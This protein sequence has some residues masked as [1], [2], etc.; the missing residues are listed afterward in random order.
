[1]KLGML[2]TIC[3]QLATKFQKY[4]CY[5]F[6]RNLVQR[7]LAILKLQALGMR[8][9]ATYIR[10]TKLGFYSTAALERG[11]DSSEER[12]A[13]YFFAIYQC[14]PDEPAGI[15]EFRAKLKQAFSANVID[16]GRHFILSGE[17]AFRALT[18][19]YQALTETDSLSE[20]FRAYAVQRIQEITKAHR[21][22]QALPIPINLTEGQLAQDHR[23][24]LL[25]CVAIR[26]GQVF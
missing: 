26:N 5:L 16:I 13:S 11:L 25:T 24:E 17:P 12:F 1:M 10:M 23:L 15:N 6:H 19:Y 20:D 9:N 8:N 2:L 3:H 4:Q 21:D 22:S 18:A 7:Q 14:S